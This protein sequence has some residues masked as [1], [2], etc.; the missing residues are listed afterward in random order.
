MSDALHTFHMELERLVAEV[1]SDHVAT[2]KP[3]IGRRRSNYAGLR[4]TYRRTKYGECEYVPMHGGSVRMLSAREVA[5]FR[6]AVQ[7]A[8]DAVPT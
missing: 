8:I 2:F 3:R 1:Q 6:A 4:A 7:R 5:E